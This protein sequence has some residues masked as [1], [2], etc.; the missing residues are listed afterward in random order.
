[1]RGLMMDTPLLIS[2][3]IEH[4]AVV[5]GFTEIVT[6]TVEGPIHRYTWTEALH[7]SKQLAQALRAMGVRGDDRVG[8]HRVEHPPPFEIY[9][10]VSGTGAVVHTVNPRLH[11]GQLVYVAQPR[12]GPGAVRATSRSCPWSR[13]CGTNSGP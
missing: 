5:F 9:Y 11:P 6:R 4:A 13:P 7:R 8:H 3:L 12:R 1:M 10:G 2:S